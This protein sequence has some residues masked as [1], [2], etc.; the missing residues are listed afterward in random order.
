MH[1]VCSYTFCLVDPPTGTRP[2]AA[3]ADGKHLFCDGPVTTKSKSD[4]KHRIVHSFELRKVQ[5]PKGSNNN[6]RYTGFCVLSTNDHCMTY[7]RRSLPD[8]GYHTIK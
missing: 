4:T 6:F 8:T 5:V 3:L 7:S 1:F 2:S